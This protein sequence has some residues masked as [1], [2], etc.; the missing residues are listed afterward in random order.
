MATQETEFDMTAVDSPED[1]LVTQ[2]D[3]DEGARST[4]AASIKPKRRTRKK[5]EEVPSEPEAVLPQR[6]PRQ[7]EA[8]VAIDDYRTVETEEDKQQ[9]DLLDLMESLKT[10]KRL[11]GTIQGVERSAGTA[12]S[13]AIVYHGIYKIMIPASEVVNPPADFRGREPADVMHYLLL[14]RMGAEIDYIVLGIDPEG[15]AAGSRLQ[16][17]ASKC[18]ESYFATDNDGN[19]RLHEGVCAEARVVSVIRAGIFIDLFGVECY[20]PL[21]ELSYQRYLDASTHFEPGQRVLVHITSLDRSDRDHIQVTA[22]IKQTQQDPYEQAMR[23]YMVGNRYVGVVSVVDTN[24]VFVALD[25]IDCLC[26]YPKRG[27]PPKGARV[28]VRILGINQESHR[29]W[30]VITHIST[31]IS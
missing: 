30:G 9:N 31:Q 14:K 26:P 4:E 17:M 16:A 6:S 5:A 28:T 19:Y 13:Y 7:R 23:K 20:I 22:S 24:G 8:I 25:G 3:A 27:R 29:I 21:R 1:N 18:R 12:E 10:K 11:T 15:L 2:S